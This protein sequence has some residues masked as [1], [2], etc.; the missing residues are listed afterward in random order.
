M[1]ADEVYNIG[2]IGGVGPEAHVSQAHSSPTDLVE[3]REKT[4]VSKRFVG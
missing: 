2:Q 1:E 3:G 4:R